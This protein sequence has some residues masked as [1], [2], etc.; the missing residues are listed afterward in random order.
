ML[1]KNAL[2]EILFAEENLKEVIGVLEYDP[3]S[4]I[5]N[6]KRHRDFL[7]DHANY[8]EVRCFHCSEG[9]SWGGGGGWVKDWMVAL[10]SWRSLQVKKCRIPMACC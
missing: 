8:K 5:E 1:N 10:M 7:W 2:F 9:L 3:D 4:S 6:R